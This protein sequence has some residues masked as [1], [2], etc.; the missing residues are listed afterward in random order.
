MTNMNFRKVGNALLFMPYQLTKGFTG[1][2]LLDQ[3][4]MYRGLICTCQ[5]TL[6]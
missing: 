4:N 5:L 1:T 6:N 2:L 3:G